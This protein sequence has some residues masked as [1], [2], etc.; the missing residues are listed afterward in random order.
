MD[1]YESAQ[2]EWEGETLAAIRILGTHDLSRKEILE[3]D[4]KYLI[5]DMHKGFVPGEIEELMDSTALH[6]N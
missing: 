6:E 2:V 4:K 1:L 5:H 3:E